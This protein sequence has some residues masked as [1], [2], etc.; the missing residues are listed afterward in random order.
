MGS[1]SW[2]WIRGRLGEEGKLSSLLRWRPPPAPSRANTGEQGSEAESLSTSVPRVRARAC[3]LGED[4]M[5][6]LNTNWPFSLW[7]GMGDIGRGEANGEP[8]LLYSLIPS[9]NSL[10]SGQMTRES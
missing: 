6:L 3:G 9:G 10:K 4:I 7:P 2:M 5:V 8:G 1:Q